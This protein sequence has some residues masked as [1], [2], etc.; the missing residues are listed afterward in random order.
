MGNETKPIA[1]YYEQQDWF[2]P[3]FAELDRGNDIRAAGRAA[4]SVR[5]GR[6]GWSVRIDFQSHESFGVHRGEM[7]TEFSI[8]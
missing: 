6:N 7:Q 3:L 4:T 5:S 1:I 2:R 8:R